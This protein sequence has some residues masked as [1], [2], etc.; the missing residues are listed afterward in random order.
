MCQGRGWNMWG[1]SGLRR[2]N[3]AKV[4]DLLSNFCFLIHP[5]KGWLIELAKH[6][7]RGRA[8]ALTCHVNGII[9][10]QRGSCLVLTGGSPGELGGLLPLIASLLSF[11]FSGELCPPDAYFWTPSSPGSMAG[12]CHARQG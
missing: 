9:L 2:R 6:I 1:L 12:Q 4:V 3:K 7:T 11:F 10:V 5:S 8:V